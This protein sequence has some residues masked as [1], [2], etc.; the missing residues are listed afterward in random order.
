MPIDRLR[1]REQRVFAT[2]ERPGAL[3]YTATMPWPL[4]L[5]DQGA[6]FI[7]IEPTA[8]GRFQVCQAYTHPE[9][10]RAVD[11]EVRW[12]YSTLKAAKRG[13]RRAVLRG[14]AQNTAAPGIWLWVSM[15]AVKHVP[16]NSLL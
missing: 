4:A 1:W 8:C 14:A 3:R 11:G 12:V 13:A 5:D 6:V 16:M 10:G 2:G 15:T 7:V 9:P